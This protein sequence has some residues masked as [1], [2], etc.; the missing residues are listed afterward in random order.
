[1]TTDKS[2]D[3]VV[4]RFLNSWCLEKAHFADRKSR[5]PVRSNYNISAVD[6][7]LNN[8]GTGQ[9]IP[10]TRDAIMAHA[11]GDVTIGI[12]L[13]H[14]EPNGLC[15]CQSLAWDIDDDPN[16]I[17]MQAVLDRLA[18]DGF[19]G[20]AIKTS[21][22]ARYV[23][24]VLDKP[25]D[26]QV[27]YAY[28]R[29]I[30]AGLTNTDGGDIECFP[31]QPSIGEGKYG[32]YAKLP[33]KHQKTG[34]WAQWWNPETEQYLDLMTGLE[35]YVP[36][37]A[38]RIEIG[39]W[40]FDF[41]PKQKEHAVT[42][43]HKQ[44]EERLNYLKS[45]CDKQ[46]IEYVVKGMKVM[47]DG[48]PYC[49]A[50]LMCPFSA[51]HTGGEV[52]VNDAYAMIFEDRIAYYCSHSHCRDQRK[53]ID[54]AIQG[55]DPIQE[56]VEE[57]KKT[58]WI[59][60]AT[61]VADEVFPLSLHLPA[62]LY[63]LYLHCQ[64]S[65]SRSSSALMASLYTIAASHA[66]KTRIKVGTQYYSG[67][68]RAADLAPSGAGKT[69]DYVFV[70][71]LLLKWNIIHD[72]MDSVTFAAFARA[73]GQEIREGTTDVMLMDIA[74]KV[75]EKEQQCHPDSIIVD[76]G[77]S[78]INAMSAIETHRPTLAEFARIT[79]DSRV[80]KYYTIKNGLR[81]F[82]R[83][84]FNLYMNGVL[85]DYCR[86]AANT[87]VLDSGVTGRILPFNSFNIDWLITGDIEVSPEAD[88]EKLMAGLLVC[89]RVLIEDLPYDDGMPGEERRMQNEAI[90]QHELLQ[91]YAKCEH[92]KFNKLLPKAAVQAKRLAGLFAVAVEAFS[93]SSAVLG[94]EEICLKATPYYSQLFSMALVNYFSIFEV[95]DRTES[96]NDELL[97][98]YLTISD[99][100]DCTEMAILANCHTIKGA[101]KSKSDTQKA[102]IQRMKSSGMIMERQFPSG[103]GSFY[104]AMP[105]GIDR[106]KAVLNGG[107]VALMQ[108]SIESN[109]PITAFYL[110]D[111][112]YKNKS[113]NKAVKA[114]DSL[115]ENGRWTVVIVAR[116]KGKTS[117]ELTIST[118]GQQWLK[119][120]VSCEKK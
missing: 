34:E 108:Y 21:S 18:Q 78:F 120:Q 43:D 118:I 83:T 102:C 54:I 76:D 4:D 84:R 109:K 81:V 94:E 29:R 19:Q 17:A 112:V 60:K 98:S 111:K 2:L 16:D 37:S 8:T 100:D 44:I 28:V 26:A 104:V 106:V 53:W 1:M 86:F 69:P 80:V 55:I 11:C 117:K 51:N 90:D 33:G 56:V 110:M 88:Y 10:L 103:I 42:V 35:Q 15:Q 115:A 101:F 93:G 46:G 107:E 41:V 79:D 73:Y 65:M 6:A 114:I 23:W 82:A 70:D 66:V 12:Y 72:S 9:D 92:E 97:W 3:I 67:C 24:L 116:G 20:F 68:M 89:P 52:T 14:R 58:D 48:V 105:K 40:V 91:K 85:Q 36:E 47:P 39:E 71:E 87:K 13:V 5:M 7:I 45:I 113:Y 49:H 32:N 59:S 119:E 95:M 31:K 22:S 50:N 75:A 38:D 74:R 30:G 64:K 77:M 61:L 62:G 96:H 63:G 25:I 99:P 27:A 57:K